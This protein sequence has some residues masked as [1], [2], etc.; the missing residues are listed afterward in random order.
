[1]PPED[2]M[3]SKNE[4]LVIEKISHKQELRKNIVVGAVLRKL[5]K[6]QGTM[7]NLLSAIEPYL[8]KADRQLFGLTF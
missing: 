6:E 1:M 4:G 8:K 5:H 2:V 7:A 3:E